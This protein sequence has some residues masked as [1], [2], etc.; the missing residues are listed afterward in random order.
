MPSEA[1]LRIEQAGRQF[2][3]IRAESAVDTLKRENARLRRDKATLEDLV[4]SLRAQVLDAKILLE[5]AGMSASRVSAV[6][7]VSQ[8]ALKFGVPI[9]SVLGRG[10]NAPLPQ[11]RQEAWYRLASE[12]REMSALAIGSLFMVDH[13]SVLYGVTKHCETHALARPQ[14]YNYDLAAKRRRSAEARARHRER[15]KAKG[16]EQR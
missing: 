4:R 8:V 16:A 7:I 1:F 11:A 10:R 15:E 3:A 14:G 6:A 13:T 2:Q 5:N 9:E 12:R